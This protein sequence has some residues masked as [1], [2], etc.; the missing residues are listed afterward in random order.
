MPY[1]DIDLSQI[2]LGNGLLPNST[3]PLPKA[4]LTCHQMGSVALT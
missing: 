4:I 3:K 1:G 2:V